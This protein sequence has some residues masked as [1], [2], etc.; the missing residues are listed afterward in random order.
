M[1][2]PIRR[3]APLHILDIQAAART[4]I[5]IEAK[6]EADSVEDSTRYLRQS[7]QPVIFT[8]V[9]I[10]KE[11]RPECRS[12]LP[13]LSNGTVDMIGFMAWASS[14]RTKNLLR[15]SQVHPCVLG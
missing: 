3:G 15:I 7:V 13:R 6:D 1:Y 11:M 4:Q 5:I 14:N 2:A 9:L 12:P 8:C 10:G